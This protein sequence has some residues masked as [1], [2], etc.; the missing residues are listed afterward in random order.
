M[1]I[2]VPVLQFSSVVLA[3]AGLWVLWESPASLGAE[4]ARFLGLALIFAAGGDLVAAQFLRRR[5]LES[6]VRSKA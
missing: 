6:P 5:F 4:T 3:A 2:V 1:R